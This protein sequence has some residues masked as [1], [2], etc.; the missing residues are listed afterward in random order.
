MTVSGRAFCLLVACFISLP[1]LVA[2][3]PDSARIEKLE[4]TLDELLRQV[5]EIRRELDDLKTASAT[6]PVDTGSLADVQPIEN[7]PVAAASKALNPDI[8]VIGTMVGHAGERN[9][10]EGAT[11]FEPEGEGRAPFAFEEAEIAF[12]AFIDPYAK[13]RF[14]V[15]IEDGAAELEEGYAQFVTLPYGLTAKAGKV[16]ASFGKANT[17]HTHTRPWV[18]RPLMIERF[19]G[20]GLTDT[21]I[22][23]S[24]SIDNPWNTFIEATGEVLS[25]DAEGVFERDGSNDLFY[26]VHLKAFRDLSESSNVE[27]GT[28]WSRGTIGAL[29]HSDF[30]GVDVTYRWKPLSQSIY[31]S[32]I[33]RFEGLAN[34]RN[35]SDR[36]LYGFY[37]SADYQLARRWFAGVRVDRAD[38]AFLFGQGEID[39]VLRSTDR[40]VS[41]TLTFWPSEFSQVRGQLRRTSYGSLESINEFLIQL[42]FAIGAHGA[43][44]F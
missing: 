24:K 32:F 28:S 2:Q 1:P 11:L 27:V 8:S 14:F 34:R 3:Q 13:G 16:K 38:R 21:G 26:N 15:A 39:P 35:D 5:A 4:Q 19:F 30:S 25:G 6:G 23:V 17:W 41:A 44:T 12:E 42:Q 31:K 36:T 7:Q 18:D 9:L 10:F 40:G 33:G 37:A 20:E 22:S 43:H 29:G